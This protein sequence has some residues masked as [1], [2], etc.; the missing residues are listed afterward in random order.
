MRF[1]NLNRAWITRLLENIIALI[2]NLERNTLG[3]EKKNISC[4]ITLKIYNDSAIDGFDLLFE[5]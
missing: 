4:L 1:F 3:L 2:I 5:M